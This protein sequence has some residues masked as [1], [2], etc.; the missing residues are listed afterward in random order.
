M[1]AR[2][3]IELEFEDDNFDESIFVDLTSEV[4]YALRGYDVT[5]TAKEYYVS[6]PIWNAKEYSIKENAAIENY[7]DRHIEELEDLFIEK[8]ERDEI[9]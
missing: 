6:Y 8:F 3:T 2:V 1:K 7:I 9:N 5:D 4:E